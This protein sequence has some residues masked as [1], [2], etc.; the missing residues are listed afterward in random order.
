MPS[1]C[2]IRKLD[3]RQGFYLSSFEFSDETTLVQSNGNNS[4]GKTT[5][6]RAIL[7]ALG[8]PVASTSEF[9]FDKC[10]FRIELLRDGEVLTGLRSDGR[11]Q[12]LTDGTTVD[13]LSL[14]VQL[15]TLRKL[16][17]GFGSNQVRDNYLGALY[18]DQDKGWTLLNRGKV[19]ADIPFNIERFIDGLSND[20]YIELSRSIDGLTN[21]IKRY[22]VV[23]KI[24]NVKD[25][26]REGCER[27]KSPNLGDSEDELAQLRIQRASAMRRRNKIRAILKDNDRFVKYIENMRLSVHVASGEEVAVTKENLVGYDDNREYQMAEL[28]SIG[29]EIAALDRRIDEIEEL[30]SGDEALFSVAEEIDDAEA[31]I[32]RLNIRRDSFESAIKNLK[33]QRR[34][35]AK[36]LR[37]SLG[38]ANEVT[39]YLTETIYRCCEKLGVEELFVSD[40]KGIFTSDLKSKS[41][42]NKQ[43]MVLAFRIGYA[44]TIEH[45]CNICLPFIVDSPRNGEVSRENFNSMINLIEE[46]LSNRQIIIASIGEIGVEPQKT[47]TI[48][49]RLMENASVLEDID[50]CDIIG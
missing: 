9:H 33:N 45:F 39:S 15:G 3:I 18:I 34:E 31:Q 44:K 41:G 22:D 30:L 46:E 40:Q 26:L 1:T 29:M 43:L 17:W 24:A 2:V 11:Y 27:Y 49:S 16:L 35:E 28:M 36:K 50:L 12:I 21:R 13:C 5:L 23:A 32:V 8:E 7:Y 47:I 48:H 42:T 14:P 20:K 19:T 6:L 4:V 10:E 38:S 37:E 25:E